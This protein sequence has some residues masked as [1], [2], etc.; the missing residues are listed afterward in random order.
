ML[1]IGEPLGEEVLDEG[2][3]PYDKTGGGEAA[4]TIGDG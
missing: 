2:S 4:P 1:C 3:R